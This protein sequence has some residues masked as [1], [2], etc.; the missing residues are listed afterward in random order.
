MEKYSNDWN[1]KFESTILNLKDFYKNK[2]LMIYSL[3]TDRKR[4]DDLYELGKRSNSNIKIAIVGERDYK[5]LETVKIHNLVK[6]DDFVKEK[7]KIIAKYV[8]AYKISLLYNENVETFK[9]RDFII[10]NISVNFGNALNELY[11]YKEQYNNINNDLI[12][13]LALFC[14]DNNFFDYPI[15]QTYKEVVKEIH[16]INF[17]KLF[18]DKSRYSYSETIKEEAIPIIR[19]LLVSRKFRMDYPHYQTETVLP[20]EVLEEETILED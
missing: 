7:H 12:K 3:D 2:Y 1:C 13:Q 14:E 4:L 16:K 15:Y 9:S 10:K 18:V 17:I 5:K 19:E 8:T 11:Q 20:T 6:M